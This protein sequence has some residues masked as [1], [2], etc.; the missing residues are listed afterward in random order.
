MIGKRSPPCE[1]YRR[2]PLS[3]IRER[4][5]FALDFRWEAKPCAPEV[6][7]TPEPNE[8]KYHKAVG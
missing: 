6:V 7:R 1:F 8:I 4:P 2:D 5:D 3:F